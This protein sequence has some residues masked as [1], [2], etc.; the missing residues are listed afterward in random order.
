MLQS[1]PEDM[2]S[3]IC[4]KLRPMIYFENSNVVQAGESLD[5]MLIIIEG[6]IIC[7][8]YLDQGNTGTTDSGLITKYLNKGDFCGEELLSWGSPNLMFSGPAPLSTLEVKC[9]TKVEAFV[10]KADKLRS[11]VS[12]YSTEWT[13]NFNNSAVGGG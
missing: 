11:L 9:Q 6:T 7:T 5:L 8:K 13:S 1:M 4:Y 10:L 3:N 12:E 2:F